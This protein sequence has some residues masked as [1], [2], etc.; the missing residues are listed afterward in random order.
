MKILLL[1]ILSNISICQVKIKPV[2]TFSYLSKGSDYYYAKNSI[3]IIGAGVRFDYY[4]DNLDIHALFLNHRLW[5]V[6]YVEKK[7]YNTFNH[8]QGLSW[9]QDPTQ[10]KNSFDYDF[11][12]L[13][14]NYYYNNSTFLL[15]KLIP[16]GVKAI[17]NSFFLI[18]LLHFHYS[19]L[20]GKLIKIYQLNIF[21]VS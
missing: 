7:Y 8:N 10:S 9:A 14:I 20:I 1:L 6:P 5:G 16:N 12:N 3:S 15:E 11:A 18:R 19:V 17:Q 2:F 21:M 13:K 4:N